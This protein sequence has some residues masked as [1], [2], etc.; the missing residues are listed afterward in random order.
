MNSF[1]WD[2][3]V[4][5]LDEDGYPVYDR[6][7]KA[8]DL[9]EVYETFFSNGV[10]DGSPAPFLVTPGSGMSVLV[11]GG[12]CHIQGAIGYELSTR[13][14]AITAA[15]SQPR[16]DTVV[17]RWDSRR[18]ARS[19]DLYVVHG[20]AADRPTRPA[21]TRSED[22]WELG[23]AD[24]Y[25]PQGTGTITADRIT[26]TRLQTDRCGIVAP[27]AKFDTTGLFNQI[28]NAIDTNIAELER[29]TQI[30]IDLAQSAIGGT[31]AGD[32][33][34]KIGEKVSKA[35]DTM[36]GALEIRV[37][38][39][40]AIRLRDTSA[41][42]Y[43][44]LSQTGQN[45]YMTNYGSDGHSNNH[46]LLSPTATGLGKPLNVASGGTG[47]TTPAAACTNLIRGQAIEPQRI[48]LGHGIANNS[49]GYIDFHHNG[50]TADHTSR[51]IES[52]SGTIDVNGTPFKRGTGLPVANGGTGATTVA[53]AKSNLGIAD[54]ARVIKSFS[55]E[56]GH[57]TGSITYYKASGLIFVGASVNRVAGGS[58]VN[59]ERNTGIILP[60]GMRPNDTT[61]SCQF[62]PTNNTPNPCPNV[63][64]RVNTNGQ[65]DVW[66][67][68]IIA[69]ATGYTWNYSGW[70]V[71][72][73]GI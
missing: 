11:S 5:R 12:K 19:I 40:A 61:R 32:L 48:E 36:T 27:F 33:L 18:D 71:F 43:L 54:V 13:T 53:A 10:F 46:L 20:A 64:I 29:Q 47:A 55:L 15:T 7:Y 49:G 67:G 42:T 66:Y 39:D 28:Q 8:E 16:I 73:P 51:I 14:I 21:L 72:A 69:P 26:D 60:S 38:D 9:R 41:S 56:S 24:I 6:T 34:Q 22:V 50:S 30:A 23:I 70:L 63:G 35:G 68:A 52:A 44:K 58:V 17:L 2:S 45:S 62:V 31:V 1:P 25:I 57:I 59:G 4:D 37:D 65:V 3:L